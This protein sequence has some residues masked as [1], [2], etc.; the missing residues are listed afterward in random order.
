[1]KKNDCPVVRDLMPLVLDRVASDE[2]R[3]MVEGHIGTCAECRKQ[4]EDMKSVLP[5]DTRAEYEEEQKQFTQA[6]E[7]VRKTRIKRRIRLVALAAAICLAV[8]LAGLFS[9]DA[10]FHRYTA[11]V[12]NSLYSLSVVEMKSGQWIVTAEMGRIRFD[13][14]PELLDVN[15]DGRNICYIRLMA[16]PVH[17]EDP[18]LLVEG[19]R[20]IARF[21]NDGDAKPAEL[22]QGSPG[23]YVTVW[24][25]GEPMPAASEEMERYQALSDMY[26][27]VFDSLPATEDGKVL[28]DEQFF[29]W[30]DRVE[31][32][33]QAVPEWK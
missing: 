23:N 32:A 13:T 28:A 21:E 3:E 10:L 17:P 22:R 29:A 24:K 25:E 16:P 30:Q 11:A 19:K 20:E 8:T 15:E 18:A 12:D 31:E 5:E 9:Y 6:L 2:S 33:R 4:Y 26:W 1:M 7:A 27:N 14:N